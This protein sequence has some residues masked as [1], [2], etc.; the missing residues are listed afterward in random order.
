MTKPKPLPDISR[1]ACGRKA[2]LRGGYLGPAKEVSC[3]CGW[4]GPIRRNARGAILAWNRV[5]GACRA[6]WNLVA[7][8]NSAEKKIRRDE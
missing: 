1:C 2:L 8:V 7:H 6:V 4:S 3:E 5:M